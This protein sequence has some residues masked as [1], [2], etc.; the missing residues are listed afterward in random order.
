MRLLSGVFLGCLLYSSSLSPLYAQQ[1]Q[2]DGRFFISSYINENA[3]GEEESDL[4][5]VDVDETQVSFVDPV[6]YVGVK[7]NGVG[8]NQKDNFIYAINQTSVILADGSKIYPILRLF[9]DGTYE[10]LE[11]GEGA[12]NDIRWDYSAGDCSPEGYFVVHDQESQQLH[13]LDVSGDRVTLHRSV[14]LRW[15]PEV[16]IADFYVAM[17]D[18]VFDTN[19]DGSIYSHQRNY[20][21]IEEESPATR[22]ALLKINGNLNDPAVGAVSV[23][24]RPDPTVIV[25][26]GGMFFDATGKL[27]TYGLNTWPIAATEPRV[28]VTFNKATGE[29]TLVGEALQ[30]RTT[31]GCS[32]PATLGLAMQAATP[33]A[34]CQSTVDYSVVIR[35]NSVATVTGAVFTDTL[36]AGMQVVELVFGEGDNYEPEE[37][38]GVGYQVLTLPGL[39][40]AA[41]KEIAFT[42]RADARGLTGTVQHQAYLTGLPASL[43]EMLASDD[44]TTAEPYDPAAVTITQAIPLLTLDRDTLL[45]LGEPFTLSAQVDPAWSY[46]WTGPNGFR[47]EEA[48]PIVT[49]PEGE[50]SVYY[51]LHQQRDACTLLDSVLVRT[52]AAPQLE[53]A[54]DTTITPGTSISL[55]RVPAEI[56]DYTYLWTPA[57][58]LSCTDCANPQASPTQTTE[59]E[60]RVSNPSGCSQQGKVRVEVEEAELPEPEPQPARDVLIPNAFTPNNDGLNDVFVPVASNRVSFQQF[61]VYNRWG[62]LLFRASNFQ[63]NDASQGWDGTYRG[64]MAATGTYTYRLVALIEE[65]GRREYQGQVQLL[66]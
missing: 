43:G 55:A 56:A 63:P 61:E 53:L 42:I 7:L 65:K 1:F 41:G 58:G 21:Q 40:L 11:L 47:S 14:P 24:G 39:T 44:T 33:P 37:E 35:N 66:R 27:Y 15:A 23:V 36:P 31:D 62:E 26:V 20:E 17:N 28:L 54:A 34:T 8:Y 64:R 18:I 52:L 5:R 10:I 19:R 22:G 30:T 4:H 2:C 29:A 9:A 6:A 25:H 45:C 59:Y 60:L 51:Y 16:G 32:C 50:D 3:G 38:T 46:Y 13:Y 12:I 49:L 48:N 57:V